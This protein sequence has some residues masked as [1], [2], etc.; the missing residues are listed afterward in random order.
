MTAKSKSRA[1]SSAAEQLLQIA[2]DAAKRAE[3]WQDLHN[4]VYGVGGPFSQLFKTPAERTEF[5]KSEQCQ[6]I[7]E[8]IQAL[9]GRGG[10]VEDFNGKIL[11]RV[12]KS[13]HAAL[14]HEAEQEGVSL[15]Q[16]IVSKLSAQLRDLASV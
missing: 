7:R 12:P 1:K 14:S 9:P 6:Q 11:V 2:V 15:N 10:V 4:S 8:M 16:L 13:L 5:S 3:T